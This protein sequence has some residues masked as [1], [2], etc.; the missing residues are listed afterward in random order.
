MLDERRCVGCVAIE[1]LLLLP[2]AAVDPT[3]PL[4]DPGVVPGSG[5][6]GVDP[7]VVPGSGGR[8]ILWRIFDD[9]K[10]APLPMPGMR[11][12]GIPLPRPGDIAMPDVEERTG[13][14]W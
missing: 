4:D 6:R 9:R 14:S 3:A 10:P 2:S 12:R 7:G 5:G 11:P 13:G 8:G 1:P